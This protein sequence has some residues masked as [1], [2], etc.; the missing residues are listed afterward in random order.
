MSSECSANIPGRFDKL[1]NGYY[2]AKY[3]TKMKLH[4]DWWKFLWTAGLAKTYSRTLC[5]LN[6]YREFPDGRCQYCGHKHGSTK[7]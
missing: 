6:L 1:R 4:A 3:A 7:N 2:T 5:A